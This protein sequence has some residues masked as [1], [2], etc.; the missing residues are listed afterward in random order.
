MRRQRPGTKIQGPAHSLS[1]ALTCDYAG[2]L[3]GTRT[4]NLLIRSFGQV[5]QG[6]LLLSAL[7]IDVPGLSAHDRC[8]LTPWQQCWQ[9][10]S[11]SRPLPYQGCFSDQRHLL[12]PRS[13]GLSVCPRGDVRPTRMSNS[14]LVSRPCTN[15]ALSK[16]STR[17]RSASEARRRPAAS[18][19][20]CRVVSRLCRHRHLPVAADAPRCD[21]QLIAIPSPLSASRSRPSPRARCPPDPPQPGHDRHR[22]HQHG[23]KQDD[24]PGCQA[25]VQARWDGGGETGQEPGRYQP[26]DPAAH[27]AGYERDGYRDRDRQDAQQ[28]EGKISRRRGRVHQLNDRG[29]PEACGRTGPRS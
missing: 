7:W 6:C 27:G 28:A 9:Q 3:G 18:R 22:P 19:G 16:S 12:Q 10:S 15:A 17:S 29:E 21:D 8:R 14:S 26:R 4:P 20:S 2:A 5:V 11:A 13:A 24:E 25:A 23:D 1:K